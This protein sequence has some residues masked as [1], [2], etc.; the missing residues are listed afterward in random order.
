MSCEEVHCVVSIPVLPKDVQQGCDL[1]L[2]Q[3][4][5]V[6]SLSSLCTQGHWNRFWPL[7]FGE[8]KLDIYSIQ[9]C[10]SNFLTTV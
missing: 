1:S 7:D 9:L 6:S 3:W 8:R 10:A 4:K 5:T 2:Q